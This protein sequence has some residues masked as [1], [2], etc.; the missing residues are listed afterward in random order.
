MGCWWTKYWTRCPGT[1]RLARTRLLAAKTRPPAGGGR[2]ME[3]PRR[4]IIGRSRRG[5]GLALGVVA[6]LAASLGSA[7][8]M[9]QDPNV[10]K[11]ATTA[12]ITT[13]DPVASFS[14]EAF[15]M[16]NIYEP[17]LWIN[18]PGSETEF[19][20]ALATEW[21]HS[22]DGLTWTFQIRPDVTFHDGTPLT[23]DAV[24][25][26]IEA[27]RTRAGASFIWLPLDTVTATGPLTV[28]MQ[29]KYAAPMDLVA[30]SLYG[31]WI[32][33]PASLAAAA[34]LYETDPAA[35][36]YADGIDGGT[37]PYTIE[38]YTPGSEVLLDAYPGYWAGW[39]DADHYDKVLVSIMPEA[40]NQ[41]QALD[42]DDVDIAFN[43]P[44]ENL[45]QYEDDPD[46]TVVREPSFFNY[47]GLFNTQKAPLDDPKVREALSYA[48]PYGDIITVGPQGAGTQSRGPVPAGV[49]PYDETVPQYAYD[50][51]K[52]KTLLAEA[53]YPDGG[54]PMEI[55][56]RLRESERNPVRAAH[57]GFIRAVGHRCDA[58]PDAL[59][60][61]VGAGQG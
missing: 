5:R 19:T 41:Q 37:G 36:Y 61:A 26:S 24:V 43:V 16:G 3:R 13:W 49:F 18:P 10:L 11:V 55:D 45:G 25:A 8:A 14:T 29:L 15:Y 44:A 1:A 23:A 42:G 51:E 12:G 47:V 30:S 4:I 38:D 21:T 53:G 2:G 33:S 59:Q 20:P 6:L 7:Q 35:D 28:E 34:A 9:A 40:L 17:L 57:R 52:A 48:I 31:A 46:F 54:F 58:D 22:D 50:I 39:D 32:V 56:L 27:A 60:P